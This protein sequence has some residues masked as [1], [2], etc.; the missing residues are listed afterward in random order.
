MQI[1]AQYTSEAKET[2]GHTQAYAEFTQKGQKDSPAL[3]AGMDAIMAEFA[4]C[5]AQGH[6]PASAEAQALVSRLQGYI[7]AHFYNCTDAI[8]A[9]LGELYVA[10]DRFRANIDRHGEGTA[11]FIRQAIR[12]K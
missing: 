12:A 6:A 11:E 10:D 9:G 3:A 8:L 2:W 5:K 4:V 1:Y 7:T